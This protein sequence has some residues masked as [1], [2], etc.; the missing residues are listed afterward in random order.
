MEYDEETDSF[1]VDLGSGDFAAQDTLSQEY[2]RLKKHKALA[3]EQRKGKGRGRG[4]APSEYDP[5]DLESMIKEEQEALRK[6]RQRQERMIERGPGAIFSP[7]SRSLVKETPFTYSPPGFRKVEKGKV[8]STKSD[9]VVGITKAG[10]PFYFTKEG[11]EV[12][13]KPGTDEYKHVVELLRS[14]E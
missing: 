6:L 14:I 2:D 3:A 7:F 11:E 8:Y 9:T 5:S 10:A 13:P 12:Q 4:G 1:P